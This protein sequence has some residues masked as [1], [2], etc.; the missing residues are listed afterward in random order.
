MNDNFSI[1]RFGALLRK[2]YSEN[3]KLYLIGVSGMALLLC[4][5]YYVL[6]FNKFSA[7]A[8]VIPQTLILCISGVVM[9]MSDMRVFRNKLLSPISNTL[10]VSTHER[11]ALVWLNSAVICP[12]V[13]IA[14]TLPVHALFATFYNDEP[15]NVFA[16]CK[17]SVWGLMVY[18]AASAE[19]IFAG[20]TRI[21]NHFIA[22]VV[23]KMV[24]WLPVVVFMASLAFYVSSALPETVELD[25]FFS[26]LDIYFR[27]APVE[28]TVTY[29]VGSAAAEFILSKIFIIISVLIWLSA[30]FRFVKRQNA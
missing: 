13:M 10:P 16:F 15:V 21:K 24:I 2:H 11:F 14:L 17:Y 4:T 20:A 25:G 27:D 23:S 9:A 8:M 6:K 18:W 26:L 7:E 30:Y 12:L 28:L 19:V 5:A 29:S 1:T 3:Y 22:C